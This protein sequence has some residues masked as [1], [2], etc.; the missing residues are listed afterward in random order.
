MKTK[1]FIT[2]TTAITLLGITTFA[3][4]AAQVTIKTIIERQEV[5][6]VDGEQQARFVPTESSVPGDTLRFSILYTNI[7]DEAATGVVLDNPVP[8][9][10]IYLAETATSNGVDELLF[11][12]DGG[13]TYKKPTLLTYAITLADGQIETR[14]ASPDKYTHIRWLVNNIPPGG[15]GQVS[16]KALVQ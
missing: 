10:A 3:Q 8:N 13:T 14:V 4:A 1:R 11:S 9:G 5:V 6:T 7:G 15:T 16:Y 2:L 12:I